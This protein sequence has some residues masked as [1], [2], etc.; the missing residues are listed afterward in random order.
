VS[1]YDEHARNLPWRVGPRDTARGVRQDPYAVW[2]SEIMLQ[3]TTVAAVAPYFL[4]FLKTW[5]TVSDLAAASD[6][7]IRSAWAGLGYYRRATNLHACAKAVA[8]RGGAFPRTARE[9]ALLPGIGAYTSTAIAAIAFDEPVAVVDGNVERVVTRLFRLET[10]LPRVKDE[11]RREVAAMVPDARPGD[12][13]QAMMDLGATICT[14]RN[15]ACDLCPWASGCSARAA[16]DPER[17]PVKPPKKP[18][19]RRFGAA[20]VVVRSDGAIWCERRPDGGLLP[21]MTQVPTSAW[22]AERPSGHKDAH[23]VG[24]IDHVFTHFALTL[25]VYTRA[26]DTPP[27]GDGRWVVPEDLAAQ[28]WPTVMLKV[29][30]RAVP[31]VSDAL[32]KAR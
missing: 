23:A 15:P 25:D 30:R 9:L 8:A 3:Q 17:F 29:L 7:A 11:V 32:R 20:L 19:P 10:P 13:A 28:A 24:T 27:S 5:P 16:G 22:S 31:D 4:T 12:F 6:D 21:G 14:P 2:L 1:W 26:S 18:K